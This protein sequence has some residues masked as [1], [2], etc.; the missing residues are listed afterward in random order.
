MACPRCGE[1]CT[2]SAVAVL[3]APEQDFYRPTSSTAPESA[4][5]SEVTSR[6]AAHRARRKTEDLS[7]PLEFDQKPISPVVMRVAEKFANRPIGPLDLPPKPL[8]NLP[9]RKILLQGCEWKKPTPTGIAKDDAIDAAMRAIG[10]E[11]RLVAEPAAPPVPLAPFPR[12]KHKTAKVITFPAVQ[13]LSNEL[14]EPVAD[15]LRIFEVAEEVAPAPLPTI[16]QIEIAPQEPIITDPARFELP[17]QV[18]PASLRMHAALLD[19]GFVGAGLVAA[20]V[21]AVLSGGLPAPN[22][23]SLAMFALAAGVM[24]WLYFF[25]TL[26]YG[27]STLGMRTQNL[28]ICGFDGEA[29]RRTLLAWR[30]TATVLSLASLA[31]GFLWAFVDDDHLCWHDRMTRTYLRELA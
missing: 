23:T 22:K 2:C 14:A 26:Y 21:A 1:A 17:L 4:W 19:F 31:L 11:P 3:C 5:R 10:P 25:V 29:P 12:V 7:L 20:G 30:A 18:A 9:I 27:H 16:A 24:L 28:G 15:Q 6:I 13:A 8:P